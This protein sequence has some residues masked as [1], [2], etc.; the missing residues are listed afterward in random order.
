[1][2]VSLTRLGPYQLE[3]AQASTGL[4]T[5][6]SATD[7]RSGQ[8]S[9]V[10]VLHAYFSSEPALVRRF[11]DGLEAIQALA[12]H[13]N[14]LPPL[15]WGESDGVV[16]IASDRADGP[17]L[18]RLTEPLDAEAVQTVVDAVAAVLEYAEDAGI[19]HGD[20]K[21]ANVFYD[22][23]SGRVQVGDFGMAL[24]G[25]AA[26]P[27]TRRTL[28]TP[29]PAFTA[30]ECQDDK[31]ASSTGDTFSLAAIAWWLRTGDSPFGAPTPSMMRAKVEAGRPTLQP[32][33]IAGLPRA[34]ATLVGEALAP[35]AERRWAGPRA[36]ADALRQAELQPAVPATRVAPAVT[37]VPTETGSLYWSNTVNTEGWFSGVRR[38]ISWRGWLLRIG[39]VAAVAGLLI[40]GWAY[41]Q[42]PPIPPPPSTTLSSA[43]VPGRWEFPRFDLRNTGSV[44]TSSAAVRGELRWRFQTDEAFR[45]APA[46][47]GTSIFVSTGDRRIIALD[48]ET[49]MIRW[50]T[51]TTGPVDYTPVVAG[52]LVYVGLRDWRLLALNRHSGV[53]EWERSLGNP[54]SSP[55]TI[56]NGTLYQGGTDGRLFAIDAATGEIL[57]TYITGS[58]VSG[59]P[60]VLDDLVVVVADNGW[61]HVV[62]R[63]TGQKRFDFLIVGSATSTPTV[64]EDT[65]YAAYGAFGRR[66]A[67]LV[68]AGIREQVYP[69]EREIYFVRGVLWLWGIGDPPPPPRGS[70]WSVSLP[71]FKAT[72]PALAHG[73]IYV[74]SG[75][76]IV[77]I[78]QARGAVAWEYKAPAPISASPIVTDD[79]LY[80]GAEDGTLFAL[81]P[82]S[83]AERWRFQAG[84][85]IAAQPILASGGLYATAADGVVYALR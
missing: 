43:S 27:I 47:D 51:P 55:A 52:E 50:Q 68:A 66:T 61:L 28:L 29:H 59:S 7:L 41:L 71:G 4:A 44:P 17:N 75:P 73:R 46:S 13:P 60:A 38:R 34:V 19:N 11:F 18:E 30:P 40:G 53:I 63:T 77:A 14:L 85:A 15:L 65:A 54:V 82:N 26:D 10:K 70:R 58:Q 39:I 49:G 67:R 37:E 76:S 32:D 22:P 1:M 79:A 72:S 64:S 2:A 8:P 24:L 20:L 78:D 36:F 69:L 33:R 3:A 57:W 5:L 16:W 62:D 83:G 56:S 42:Q 23:E 12:P 81:D 21:P 80:A 45:A 31:P 84:G 9:V 48:A 74:G 35:G 6:Y 25:K